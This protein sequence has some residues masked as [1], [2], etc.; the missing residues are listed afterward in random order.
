MARYEFINPYNFIPL[1]GQDPTRVSKDQIR[2]TYTGKI[3]YRL[4]TKTPLFIPNTSRN[5]AFAESKSTPDHKSYDFFSYQDLS[6]IDGTLEDK[7]FEPV[8]P[9]SEIR[10]MIRANYEILTN[11]C[12]SAIDDN[13]VLSKRTQEKFKAGLLKRIVNPNGISYVLYEAEDCLLR[14]LGENNL[15][16]DNNWMNDDRHNSRRCYVQNNLKEGQKVKIKVKYR[17]IGKPLVEKWDDNGK[18]GYVIKGGE[19]PENKKH[20]CH[21]FCCKDKRKWNLSDLEIHVLSVVLSCY[22]ENDKKKIGIYDEYKAEWEK[23]QKGEG[24][25]MFPVYF[26]IENKNQQYILLTPAC[27]SREIYKNK[28]NNMIKHHVSC[29]LNSDYKDKLCPACALFGTLGKMGFQNSSRVRFS[30][31]R[32]DRKNAEHFYNNQSEM[33]LKKWTTKPLG[34]PKISNMEF[35]VRRPADDAWFWTYDYYVTREV[36]NKEPIMICPEINGRKFYWHQMNPQLSRNEDPNTQNATIRPLKSGVY[37]EGEIY[38][39]KL[40]KEELDKLIYI[41]NAGD[42]QDIEIKEHGYKLGHAK[43]LGL[44]SIALS[45][46][47]VFLRKNAMDVE[48]RSIIYREL[49]YM[50]EASENIRASESWTEPEIDKEI[51]TNFEIMTNFHYVEGFKGKMVDYPRLEG[52]GD[53]Y[54]WFTKN[55]SGF[56]EDRRANCLKKTDMPMDRKHM[57]YCEYMEPMNP[58]LKET[59]ALKAIYA[60]NGGKEKNTQNDKLKPHH[61]NGGYTGK[62]QS[63]NKK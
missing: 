5:D 31:M 46:D 52:E 10:G 50:G 6:E 30:D 29:G 43:P 14:T 28:L 44:G 13:G 11:S 23:F 4:L 15:T 38:F 39:E 25:E 55:H 12:M 53:I 51:K 37:F 3:K 1:N 32:M 21:V 7:Y 58:V 56:K 62:R 17:D 36:S 61:S 40:T 34:S 60:D 24:E 8:I 22:T 19:G 18:A 33:F 47:Q 20:C 35:Y 63:W 26:S 48:N 57:I 49:L 42:N 9:G 41:V 59:G 16:I 27:I 54:S 45:V 2:G